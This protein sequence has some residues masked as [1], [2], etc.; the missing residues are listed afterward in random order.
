MT[1]CRTVESHTQETSF[2]QAARMK[3]FARLKPH[4]TTR[5][6]RDNLLAFEAIAEA[7]GR[8]VTGFD[9]TQFGIVLIL[10][11]VDLNPIAGQHKIL[12]LSLFRHRVS[13]HENHI[14]F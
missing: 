8:P 7:K 14:L 10:R 11:L 4:L 5:L 9:N 13:A 3:E 2:K 1:L 12:T 6:E